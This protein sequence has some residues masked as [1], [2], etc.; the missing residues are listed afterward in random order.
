[1]ESNHLPLLYQRSVLAGELPTQSLIIIL[2]QIYK[3]MM[4]RSETFFTSV[5]CMDGRVQTPIKHF[6][7]KKFET[8]YPDTI[9]EAGLVGLLSK[10]SVDQSLLDSIKSKILISLKKHHSKGI[11]VHGHEDC[12]G[13]PVD[14]KRHKNDTRIAAQIIASL[15]PEGIKTIPVFVKRLDNEWAIEEL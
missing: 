5:G 12:A 7:Q 13:N 8:E 6:G 4:L 15:V 9:T 10:D 1:M 3:I 11:V 14:D 2:Y